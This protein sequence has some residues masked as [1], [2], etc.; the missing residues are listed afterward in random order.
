[1]HFCYNDSYHYGWK[2][3]NLNFESIIY[4]FFNAPFF[5]HQ[6]AFEQMEWMDLP[7]WKR[8]VL[9]TAFI[10]TIRHQCLNPPRNLSVLRHII[11]WA[12]AGVQTDRLQSHTYSSGS[13]WKSC[14]ENFASRHELFGTAACCYVRPHACHAVFKRSN[15]GSLTK[16]CLQILID[17]RDVGVR[18]MFEC[19]YKQRIW[20]RG[21]MHAGARN[22]HFW[23]SVTIKLIFQLACWR[24]DPL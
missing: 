19:G 20:R 12:V 1:M 24:S 4:H 10:F 16:D 21:H 23:F 13:T 8:I 9:M 14:T 22:R 7:Y 17:I 18:T 5:S 3:Y 15:D 6:A 2:G 11:L